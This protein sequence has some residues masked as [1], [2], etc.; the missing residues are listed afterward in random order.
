[1]PTGVTEEEIMAK[2]EQYGPIKHFSLFSNADR[3]DNMAVAFVRYETVEAGE[4]A[5]AGLG[6]EFELAGSSGKAH[7][8]YN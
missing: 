2:V 1:M 4:A 6:E 3:G 7:F 8:Q 5:M